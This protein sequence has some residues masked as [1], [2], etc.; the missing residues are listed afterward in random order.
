VPE[1]EEKY[2]VHGKQ[3]I[4]KKELEF[5][6]IGRIKSEKKGIGRNVYLTGGIKKLHDIVDN[7]LLPAHE[8]EAA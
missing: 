6:K 7:I 4:G 5:R 2:R 3:G 1:R 8:F